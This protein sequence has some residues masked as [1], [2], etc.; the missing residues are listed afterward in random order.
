M[1]TPPNTVLRVLEWLA[2][3]LGA[4]LES[5]GDSVIDPLDEPEITEQLEYGRD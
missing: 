3:R 2:E 4:D 5:L 1:I